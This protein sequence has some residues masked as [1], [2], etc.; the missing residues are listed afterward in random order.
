MEENDEITIL[1][2]VKQNK[3]RVN[4]QTHEI[5]FN[6]AMKLQE[7]FSQIKDWLKLEETSK[8]LEKTK[9]LKTTKIKS[10]YGVR[11]WIVKNG[12]NFLQNMEKTLIENLRAYVFGRLV[13]NDRKE[14]GDIEMEMNGRLLCESECGL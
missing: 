7:I 1:I 5:P 12:L 14:I 3:L 11:M 6:K 2:L 4:F 10:F 9:S 8:S 13:E